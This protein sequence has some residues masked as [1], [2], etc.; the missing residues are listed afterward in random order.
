MNEQMER[1]PTT[2]KP[3]TKSTRRQKR[4]AGSIHANFSKRKEDKKWLETHVWHAKRMKMVT[5]WGYQLALYPNDKSHRSL[6][7]AS[8]HECVMH[9]N[10]YHACIELTGSLDSLARIL[11]LVTDLT[12]NI[13]SD[14]YVKGKRLGRNYLYELNSFPLGF[15]APFDFYFFNSTENEM[16]LWCW[17][18]PSV[19]SEAMRL[20]VEAKNISLEQKGFYSRC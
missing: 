13:K 20:F 10:S 5:R 1:D 16:G 14:M 7:R 19:A 9:D 2:Q 17:F 8:Q 3:K 12:V 15:V 4:R 11:V 6:Y 18:H